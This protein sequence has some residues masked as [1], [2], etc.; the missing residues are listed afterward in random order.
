VVVLVPGVTVS[1]VI[2][3]ALARGAKGAVWFELG[4]TLARLTMVIVVAAALEAVTGLVSAIFDVIKYA[5]VIYLIWL[6]IGYLRAQGGFAAGTAGGLELTPRRQVLSGFLVLWGNPKALLFFG[7]FLPLF[8]DRAYPAA[9]QVVVLGLIEMVAASLS[10]GLYI[11][12]AATARARLTGGGAL[13]L[14]RIAGVVLIGAAVWLA[15]QN[16]A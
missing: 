3:T 10:D 6:G 8:V 12:L 11:V 16:R 13:W 7:A 5:G 2:G 1:T 9:P 15:L 4:A 14:N